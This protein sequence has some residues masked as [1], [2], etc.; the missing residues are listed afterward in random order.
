MAARR[1]RSDVLEGVRAFNR[2]YT[3]RIGVLRRDLLGT[4]F[5]LTEA[6][7]LFELRQAGDTTASAL[8]AALGLDRGQVSRLLAGLERR[9]LLARRPDPEDGRRR[10][11]RLSASGRAAAA[12]LDE[13]AS[14]EVR[15]LLAPLSLPAR[16]DVLDAMATVRGRLCGGPGAAPVR[17]RTH[18]PGDIGWLIH[19]HGV[20]Y[21][22][23]YGFDARFEALVADIA[24][25]F[26]NDHDPDRERLWIA[27]QA[28][29]R[30]GAVMLVESAPNVAQLRLLLVE[31]SARC[32]GLGTRLVGTCVR[33]ARRQGYRRM[34]LWTQ[35]NL[36]PARRL[37]AR[38][39]F[40]VAETRRHAGW[41]RPLLSESW[42]LEL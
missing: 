39:G 36:A 26:V 25:R 13:R 28:G 37:Y 16:R 4:P 24:A 15:R 34:V 33:F 30:A 23:E 38:A 27:E 41:G 35:S 12:R 1:I 8:V 7:I 29:A 31:P 18:R 22:E 17:L 42:A 3:Q 20:L 19:R 5:T 6:R 9:G 2:F 32:T 11:V 40:H 21:D 14:A 10:R